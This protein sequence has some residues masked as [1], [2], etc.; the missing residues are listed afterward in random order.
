MTLDQRPGRLV[1]HVRGED[2]ELNRYE[3]LRTFVGPL[4]EGAP[5]GEPPDDHDAGETLDR[6]VE[7][8]PI[9]AIEPATAPAMI[10]TAPSIAMYARLSHDSHLAL[11]ASRRYAGEPCTTSPGVLTS[12]N[13]SAGAFKNAAVGRG[14]RPERDRRADVIGAGCT[15]LSRLPP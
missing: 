10:A 5:A 8:K 6:G 3:L 2:V 1:G 11:L 12:T 7:A 14:P 15:S 13:D 4:G 9:S